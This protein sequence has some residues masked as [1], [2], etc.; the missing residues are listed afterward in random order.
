MCQDADLEAACKFE[1]LTHVPS[2]MQRINAC[3]RPVRLPECPWTQC[4]WVVT[5][6]RPYLEHLSCCC[7]QCQPFMAW[8]VSR[9]TLLN[10]VAVENAG[11]LRCYVALCQACQ[12]LGI[13]QL[14]KLIDL[15]TCTVPLS[16]SCQPYVVVMLCNM[17]V[18]IC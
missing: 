12:V 10:R 17:A 3:R 4:T 2:A 6:S 7:V 14:R 9:A 11:I 8:C 5:S 18:F 13:I 1:P 15:S 16:Q